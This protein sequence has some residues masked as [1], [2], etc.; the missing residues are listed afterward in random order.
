VAALPISPVHESE[1]TSALATLV[2]AFTNDPVERWLYPETR[3]YLTHFPAFL[4]AFGGNG[5]A[6]NRR[7]LQMPPRRAERAE[8]Y[9]DQ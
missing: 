9:L 5:R 4:A 1:Q 2:S 3:Q 7:P 6:V 8:P